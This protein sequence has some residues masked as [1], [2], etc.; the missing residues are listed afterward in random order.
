MSLTW[1]RAAKT[2]LVTTI[3]TAVAFFANFFS[4]LMPISSFGIFAAMLIP[5]NYL[6]VIFILPAHII[7]HDRYFSK[8]YSVAWK[9]IL[10]LFKK[11]PKEKEEKEGFMER[12]FEGPF[13][14]FLKYGRWAIVPFTLI[15]FI[16]AGVFAV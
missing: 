9:F 6:L 4:Q 10:K 16:I 3:T 12:F 15:C 7:I 2:A 11:E 14:T 5:I 8:F 1:R 13:M